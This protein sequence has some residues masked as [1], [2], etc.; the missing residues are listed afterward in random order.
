MA[1]AGDSLALGEGDSS[2]FFF[3]AFFFGD[4]EGDADSSA[5]AISFF[6]AEVFLVVAACVVVAPMLVVA[7]VSSFL[8][9]QEVTSATVANV[10]IKNKMGFFIDDLGLAGLRMLSRT[11]EGKY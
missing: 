7:E 10:V 3:D 6:L 9:M 4:S 5:V 11:L 8:V 2:A 1:P